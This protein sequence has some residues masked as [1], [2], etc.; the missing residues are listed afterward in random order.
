M[1]ETIESPAP[2]PVV[3]ESQS[4]KPE[5]KKRGRKPAA[6]K[7]K[8]NRAKAVI[9]LQVM[10]NVGESG[11]EWRGYTNAPAFPDHKGAIAWAKEQ[12]ATGK[13]RTIG[14]GKTFKLEK[15]TK[16]AVLFE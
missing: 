11:L 10:V 5:R 4:G 3:E 14:V 12:D 15:Q 2:A 9:E 6:E 16:T 8:R 1:P 13:F 7:V